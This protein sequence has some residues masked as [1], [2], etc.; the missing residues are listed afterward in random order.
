MSI[1][2]IKFCDIYGHHGVALQKLGFYDTA[3]SRL[4]CGFRLFEGT[5]FI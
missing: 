2:R 5:T 1:E 4:V 3:L